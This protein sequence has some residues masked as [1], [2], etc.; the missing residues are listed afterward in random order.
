[1]PEP[2]EYLEKVI[3]IARSLWFPPPIFPLFLSWTKQHKHWHALLVSCLR[4]LGY[5]TYHGAEV[6]YRDVH[7]MEMFEEALKAKYLGIGKPYGKTEFDTWL[8]STKFPRYSSRRLPLRAD[9]WHKSIMNT[10]GRSLKVVE[11]FPLRQLRW[12]DNFFDR[13]YSFYLIEHR[14]W[15]H[16]RALEDGEDVLKGNY[17]KL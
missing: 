3:I 4:H 17:L 15:R 13:F 6:M 9:K 14:V 7:H 2:A 1:M 10:L 12:L 16:D 8:S 11:Q 5:K